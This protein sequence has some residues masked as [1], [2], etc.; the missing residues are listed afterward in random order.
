[1]EVSDHRSLHNNW[2]FPGS[3]TCRA[4]HLLASRN[5]F[6]R[7][8]SAVDL[9][10]RS[11]LMAMAS[12]SSFASKLRAMAD[13]DAAGLS[14]LSPA[15]RRTLSE[16]TTPRRKPERRPGCVPN[17]WPT[18]IDYLTS[19]DLSSL[20]AREKKMVRPGASGRIPGI[21]IC[22]IVDEGHPARGQNGLYATRMFTN[23]EVLGE[24]TGYV[25]PGHMVASLSRVRRGRPKHSRA[26]VCKTSI[27]K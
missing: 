10:S 24:Y 19:N 3:C 18:D 14:A 16:D 8:L 4:R 27:P 7:P 12:D 26:L 2:D 25:M 1:V 13:L 23:G 22:E 21:E 9:R 17:G 11:V 5:T 6:E 15:D 20:S